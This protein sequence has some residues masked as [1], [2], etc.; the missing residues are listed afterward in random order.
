MGIMT[1]RTDERVKNVRIAN[2]MLSV[3]LMDGRIISV[4]LVWYPR[5]LN[6]PEESRQ[7]WERCAG[8]VGIHWPDL[9]EDLNV[10]GLL[11]GIPAGRLSES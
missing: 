4:P 10:D 3:D 2:D 9:D 8:G 7:K 11:R 6:A 5:L 1:S